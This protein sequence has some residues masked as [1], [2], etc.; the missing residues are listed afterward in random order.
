ML[1]VDVWIRTFHKG[2][3]NNI[4][5]KLSSYFCR[6]E[7][8]LL[9][10]NFKEIIQIVNKILLQK[11]LINGKIEAISIAIIVDKINKISYSHPIKYYK[12]I[13]ILWNNIYDMKDAF[14][15]SIIK[16]NNWLQATWASRKINADFDF[17]SCIL[18]VI[19]N[20]SFFYFYSIFQLFPKEYLNFHCKKRKYFKKKK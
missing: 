17:T 3:F 9:D 14:D 12:D 20:F 16:W 18:S 5:E 10:T 7:I 4:Q 19:Y 6:P 13:L 11:L 15:L 2:S 8:S 1:L